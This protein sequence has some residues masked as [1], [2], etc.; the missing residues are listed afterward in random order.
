MFSHL[1]VRRA[2]GH[3]TLGLLTARCGKASRT[4]PCA[5]GRS[6]IGRKRGEGDGITPLGTFDLLEAHV[7]MD[8]NVSYQSRLPLLPIRPDGGWCDAVGHANYNC[9]VS[10][11]FQASSE[12]LWREDSLYDVMIVLDYNITRRMS[13]GGSAIFF[14]I[15][16]DDFAPTEGCV[17]VSRSVM[18][19]LL[20]RLS[21]ETK[22]M[23]R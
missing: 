4:F 20:P 8:R 18:N 19:Y 1:T 11:P 7:R 3:T 2:P 14:H 5:L 10:L 21:G 12:T 22:M 15:A 16:R 17:A 6:G 13:L 23:V 9:P